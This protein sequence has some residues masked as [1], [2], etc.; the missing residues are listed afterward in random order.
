M[1]KIGLDPGHGGADR[2]NR[3]PT[4]YIEADGVLD[5][6]LACRDELIGFGYDV[7]MTRE[8][9]K[10]LTLSQRAAMLNRAG[11]DLAVSIHTN[12][13]ATPGVRGIET[14]HSIRGGPGKQLATE[15]AHRLQGDLE[16]P[17]RRVFTRESLANPGKDYYGIIR[18]TTMPCVIVEVEFHSNPEAEQ[19]LKDAEFR[20]QA[21][22]SIA[23]GIFDFVRRYGGD[24]AI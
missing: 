8:T 9:D 5:M 23:R 6:A 3:G 10:T 7:F 15:L 16:L 1:V 22:V 12:A 24:A 20:R 13:A 17:L 11:V 2:S 4:G 14:I 18:Q 19:L 21:G